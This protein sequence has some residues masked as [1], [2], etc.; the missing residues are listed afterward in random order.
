VTPPPAANAI[1]HKASSERRIVFPPF[2][3]MACR[4]RAA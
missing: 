1:R 4:H 2:I 3:V